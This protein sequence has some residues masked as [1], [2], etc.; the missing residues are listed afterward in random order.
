[1]FAAIPELAAVVFGSRNPIC[2]QQFRAAVCCDFTPMHFGDTNC[3]RLGR[4]QFLTR[5]SSQLEKIIKGHGLDPCPF[6]LAH[7]LPQVL[8]EN[9][10]NY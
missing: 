9:S 8:A 2:F 6:I 7:T 1:M 4:L 10:K 3:H 5:F